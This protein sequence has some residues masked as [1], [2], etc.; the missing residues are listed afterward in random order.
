[1]DTGKVVRPDFDAGDKPVTLTATVK[2]GLVTKT[3]AFNTIVKKLGITDGQATIKDLAWINVPTETKLDIILPLKGP[4]G[5]TI[6]WSS[7][8]PATISNLGLVTRPSVGEAD[9]TVTLTATVKKGSESQ[10]K[11][12]PVKVL[13]WTTEDE[14]E[15][16]KNLINWELIAGTNSSIN[17]V[18]S[19]LVLPAKL[20]REVTI[21]WT[22]SNRDFCDTSGKITRPTYTQGP[23][24]I[25]V[26]ATLSKSGKTITTSIP[27]IRLEPAAITNNE[28]A[29]D[30][31]NKLNEAEFLGKNVSLSQIVESM[32]LPTSIHGLLSESCTYAWTIVD[33]DDSPVVSSYIKLQPKTQSVSCTITRPTKSDGNFICYIKATATSNDLGSGDAATSAKKFRLIILAQV[34]P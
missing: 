16:A 29:L 6:S 1:M 25:S 14:L 30:A 13:A 12:F 32:E 20:G 11:G 27:G 23:V 26:V 2:K 18:I 21:A 15:N 33:E 28:I 10:T 8:T 4:N 3:I 5:T 24:I 19:N 31:V 34:S 22:T 9:L 7:G 17:M